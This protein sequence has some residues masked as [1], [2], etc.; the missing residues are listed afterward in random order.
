MTV[1]MPEAAARPTATT[2][3]TSPSNSTCN[4]ASIVQTDGWRCTA[5]SWSVP[6]GNPD[7]R[8]YNV[9]GWQFSVELKYSET[10]KSNWAVVTANPTP[11][12]SSW[13]SVGNKVRRAAGQDGGYVMEHYNN[14]QCGTVVSTGDE[15][16]QSPL[17]YSPHNLAQACLSLSPYSGTPDQIVCTNYW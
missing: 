11:G 2:C 13:E 10:C 4:G 17:V 3:A 7:I 8:R 5:N 15:I 14:C 6:K 9:N 1:G 12:H 16:I